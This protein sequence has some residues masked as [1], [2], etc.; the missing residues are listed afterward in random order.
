[1]PEQ[2]PP[3]TFA[4]IP[5]DLH[6][7]YGDFQGHP[8]YEGHW[9]CGPRLSYWKAMSCSCRKARAPSLVLTPAPSGQRRNLARDSDCSRRRTSP[10]SVLVDPSV[11]KAFPLK[12]GFA[13]FNSL[14]S[15]HSSGGRCISV[16]VDS[17][18]FRR[19]LLFL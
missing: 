17:N 12:I 3:L 18:R 1:M 13:A 4:Q 2:G 14:R 6:R 11:K 10:L 15:K 5:S 9:P 19:N 16:H 7:L 8:E